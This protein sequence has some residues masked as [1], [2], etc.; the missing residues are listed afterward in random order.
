M[1]FM[2]HR[3]ETELQTKRVHR[4]P[5]ASASFR[6]SAINRDPLLMEVTFTRSDTAVSI[7]LSTLP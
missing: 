7:R 4:L 5:A 2:L 6:I 1:L 3:S